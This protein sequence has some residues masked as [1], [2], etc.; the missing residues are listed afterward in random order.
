MPVLLVSLL[1]VSLWFL[2]GCSATG[3]AHRSAVQPQPLRLNWLVVQAVLPLVRFH[4]LRLR[5]PSGRRGHHSGGR[6]CPPCLRPPV[7]SGL[8]TETVSPLPTALR[9][10]GTST[11]VPPGVETR[12]L[13]QHPFARRCILQ[14]LWRL[15]AAAEKT[16]FTEP[17]RGV[18]RYNESNRVLR[19]ANY[20]NN[21]T[22]FYCL[23]RIQELAEH[24]ERVCYAW[25]FST[26]VHQLGE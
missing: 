8:S 17:R 23:H 11:Q 14:R 9:P 21:V 6:P 1:L 13:R 25:N 2:L 16:S 5:T 22:D 26:S 20:L 10:V 4:A 19:S 18:R 7:L 24:V 3:I 12:S 15:P